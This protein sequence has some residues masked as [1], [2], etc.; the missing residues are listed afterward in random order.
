[1]FS[2]PPPLRISFT[3]MSSRS[4]C[5]KWMIGVPGPRLLPL[6]SPVSE[7]TE[8]GPQLAALGGFRDCVLDLL[9]DPDLVHADRGLDL[10]GRHAGVLTDRAFALGGLV[11][12]L[13]DD[14][15]RLRRAR[16]FGLLVH[17]QPHRG[18]DIRRQ[19]GRGLDDE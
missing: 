12:V 18:A 3:S 19:V 8:F 15:E 6:F 17:R 2:Q 7:S 4:H 9:L 5:S 13:A 11:D 14:G 16:P 1:M 10:E